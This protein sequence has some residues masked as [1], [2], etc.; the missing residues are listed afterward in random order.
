MLI[1]LLVEMSTHVTKIA[2]ITLA[3]FKFVKLLIVSVEKCS[4][5]K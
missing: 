3:T 5:S 2:G 1:D 4:L